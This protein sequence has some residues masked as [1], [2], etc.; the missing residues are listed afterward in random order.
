MRKA[1][2]VFKIFVAN[3]QRPIRVHTILYKNKA[4]PKIQDSEVVGF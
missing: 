4:D 2:H 1:F 3:P